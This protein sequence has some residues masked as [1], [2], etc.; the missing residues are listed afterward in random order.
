MLQVFVDSFLDFL[1]HFLFTE[2]FALFL[3][4]VAVSACLWG[5]V[6]IRF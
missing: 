2:Y 5:L 4:A 3:G 6:K 1:Q